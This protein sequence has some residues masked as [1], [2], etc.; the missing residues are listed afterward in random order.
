MNEDKPRL[1]VDRYFAGLAENTFQSELG[2]VDPTLID[3]LS[4]MWCASS[5][6]TWCI[7]YGASPGSL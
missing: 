6:A 3:Y 4:A 7:E 2:I 5:V 1:T